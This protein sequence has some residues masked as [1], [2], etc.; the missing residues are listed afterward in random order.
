MPP[1]R[2]RELL[3]QNSVPLSALCFLLNGLEFLL[4]P[5]N[6]GNLWE[7]FWSFIKVANAA[8]GMASGYRCHIKCKKFG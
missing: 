4:L 1:L 3:Q 5:H 6:Q 7:P 2:R 8:D